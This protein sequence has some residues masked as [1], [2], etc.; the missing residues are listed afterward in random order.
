MENVKKCCMIACSNDST[1]NSTYLFGFPTDFNLCMSWVQNSGQPQFFEDF[2]FGGAQ[3]FLN[4]YICSDHFSEKDYIDAKDKSLGLLKGA[5]PDLN[6]SISQVNIKEECLDPEY[7]A[8]LRVISHIELPIQ[9]K[10][11]KSE[12]DN[13]DDL[14]YNYSF[15]SNDDSDFIKSEDPLSEKDAEEIKLSNDF[16]RDYSKARKRNSRRGNESEEARLMRLKRE[17]RRAKDRRSKETE[18]Q[19][20][21]RRMKNALRVSFQRK[22]ETPEQREARRVKDMVRAQLR[23]K[24]ETETQ[25]RIRKHNDAVRAA[26][27][28]QNETEE[29]RR[30]RHMKDMQRAAK[31]RSMETPEQRELRLSKDRERMSKKRMMKRIFE[32]MSHL[33]ETNDTIRYDG[34]TECDSSSTTFSDSTSLT[35]LTMPSLSSIVGHCSETTIMEPFPKAVHPTRKK[36]RANPKSSRGSESS[37]EPGSHVAVEVEA[38]DGTTNEDDSMYNTTDDSQYQQNV[39]NFLDWNRLC[40]QTVIEER[41]L[42][43]SVQHTS[44]SSSNEIDR[45]CL[46]DNRI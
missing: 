36:K 40:P 30:E 10:L 32:Q 16:F 9:I 12:T 41:E 45:P 8:G 35:P 5:I 31:R 18:E 15:S 14:S 43:A 11:E 20:K 28:R 22:N 19:T 23:R 24:T 33:N 27:R 25:A 17:A 39:L 13:C 26:H 34:I 42:D 46:E 4:R 37:D 1:K 38:Q 29:E 44:D 21:I 3:P 2:A 7:A 6:L